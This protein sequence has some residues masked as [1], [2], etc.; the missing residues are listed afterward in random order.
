MSSGSTTFLVKQVYYAGVGSGA[1]VFCGVCAFAFW[2]TWSAFILIVFAGVGVFYAIWNVGLA[3]VLDEQGLTRSSRWGTQRQILWSNVSTMKYFERDMTLVLLLRDKS[4]LPL[5]C[6]ELPGP[7]VFR[8]EVQ[9]LAL[10]TGV[11]SL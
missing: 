9:R 4:R 10:A 7:E 6:G 11:K 1:A 2:G 8:E 3:Y 5:R